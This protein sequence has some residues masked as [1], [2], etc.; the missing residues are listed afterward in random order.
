MTVSLLHT[1]V[2]PASNLPGFTGTKPSDWNAQHNL[3][4]TANSILG[5]DGG[6]VALD[7]RLYWGAGTLIG[8]TGA[9]ST[10]TLESTSGVGT[11]DAIIFQTGSQTPGM[12]INTSQQVLISTSPTAFGTSSQL[13]VNGVTS[14]ASSISAQEFSNDASSAT[15]QMY[16][17]RGVGIGTRAVVSAFDLLGTM[18]WAGAVSGSADA[19]FAKITCQAGGT[20]NATA[21]PGLLFFYVTP[22]SSTTPAEL[23]RMT[24]SQQCIFCAGGNSAWGTVFFQ[25]S[26][27]TVNG[28]GL[29][30][31]LWDTTGTDYA[32]LDFYRSKNASLNTRTALASGDSIGN[33]IWLG[34]S[35]G[36]TDGTFA[37][38]NGVCDGTP[39]SSSTPGGLIFQTTPSG[40]LSLTEAMRIDNGQNIIHG[41]AA[42][43]TNA[44]NG[45][46]YIATCAGTP[47]GTPT[48]YTGRVP[49]VF[50]TTNSQFWIYTGG[51]WKQ[52]KTPAAAALVTWQ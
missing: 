25:I 46:T 22:D 14:A 40:S 39:S 11:S 43:A 49:L 37:S 50:D 6:G 15:F 26:G 48:T 20:I 19:T 24:D 32:H 10:L 1:F 35:S 34:A 30:L 8:G 3:A 7:G 9:A 28:S 45:F 33:I 44:T 16:K 12:A 27:K 29:Q 38:I 47:T 4:G 5:Y 52:P 18:Q 2:N 17:S 13:Q 41:T 51:A 42:I 21:S 31:G 36:S 23:L